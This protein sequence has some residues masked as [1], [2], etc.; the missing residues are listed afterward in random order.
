M[1]ICGEKKKT[2]RRVRFYH[3]ALYLFTLQLGSFSDAPRRSTAAL[4]F[5]QP[6]RRYRGIDSALEHSFA[7][8]N[9]TQ[10]L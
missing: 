9:I 8:L 1:G 4:P 2:H 7:L 3:E 6:F 5:N 10:V